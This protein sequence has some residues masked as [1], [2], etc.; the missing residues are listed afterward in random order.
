MPDTIKVGAGIYHAQKR[1]LGHVNVGFYCNDCDE[2]F[3]LATL[4][5]EASKAAYDTIIEL[6]PGT[7]FECPMCHSVQAR[8]S[9]EIAKIILTPANKRRP[10]VPKDAN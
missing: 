8:E 5:K 3:A 1:K 10:P 7:Q 9:S 6:D 4:P 2:F